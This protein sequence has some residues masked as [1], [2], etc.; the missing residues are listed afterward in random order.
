MP[1]PRLVRSVAVWFGFVV[2]GLIVVPTVTRGHREVG[3]NRCTRRTAVVISRPMEPMGRFVRTGARR[4]ALGRLGRRYVAPIFSGSGR[5]AVGRTT[6]I[7]AVR[8]TTR[9]FFGNRGIRRT[10]VEMDRVVGN[11][12]PRTVRGPTGRLL[13]SSG[14]VC[15]RETTFDVSIPAVCRAIKKGGLGLSVMNIETCGRVGLCDG[16]IPRLFELT[17]NFGGRIY[18]GVYVFAGN[19]GSSLE[20]DG[21]ARLCHTTLRL[22]G[23]CGPTGR[24]CLVRRLNGASVDRRRFTRV[25]NGVQLCRYLPANCR[26][27]LPEVLLAS[28]RVGD[29][30]GTCVGSRGFND[31]KDRLGV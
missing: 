2:E 23:G 4:M 6:F 1:V 27:T 22:F 7:R 10:S 3:L 29:M 11:E 16:G 9:S 13:R 12:V 31:F 15:C 24:L 20:I 26:G 19:C 8:S 21:A 25:V 18:Y 14:A 5:L 30:T 28:A 17:V